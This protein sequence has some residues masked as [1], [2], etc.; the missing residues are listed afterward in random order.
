M[1][2]GSEDAHEQLLT[3]PMSE[4]QPWKISGFCP[5]CQKNAEFLAKG[6]WLRDELVCTSCPQ[7][8][9]PRERALALILNE[10]R[11]G[12]RGLHIHESS[13]VGRGIS[14]V[15]KRDARH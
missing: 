11:P 5:I 6:S 9:I 14:A 10:L 13:P 8:S 2:W 1:E 15:M 3:R 12:W 4:F 7:G